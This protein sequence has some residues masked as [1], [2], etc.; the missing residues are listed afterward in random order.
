MKSCSNRFKAD[1]AI[2]QFIENSIIAENPMGVILCHGDGTYEL[3]NI[4]SRNVAGDDGETKQLF[5][6][7]EECINNGEITCDGEFKLSI[8]NVVYHIAGGDISGQ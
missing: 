3:F 1:K 5:D 4:E 6:V 2:A 8:G 7:I